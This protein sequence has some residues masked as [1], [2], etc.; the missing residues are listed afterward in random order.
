[1]TKS[2]MTVPPY[3]RDSDISDGLI[4]DDRHS[5]DRM[6]DAQSSDGPDNRSRNERTSAF[7]KAAVVFMPRPHGTPN[8]HHDSDDHTG[9]D[10]IVT[11]DAMADAAGQTVIQPAVQRTRK[12]VVPVVQPV[13]C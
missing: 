4:S 1:M 10:R 9:Y 5:D 7:M 3:L 2:V 11:D 6:C 8:V 12:T 13:V